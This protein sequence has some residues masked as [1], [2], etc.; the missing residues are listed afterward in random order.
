MAG[1]AVTTARQ[2]GF[3]IGIAVLGTVFAT[4]AEDHLGAQGAPE[5]EQTAHALAAG[6]A[7]RIL[8]ALPDGLR[9][10]VDRALHGAAVAG[11]D[12]GFLVSAGVGLLGGV[13]VLILVR[14]AVPARSDDRPAEHAAVHK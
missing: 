11:L 7:G 3:A 4:R 8:A 12:A 14:P 1:G 10:T 2:L 13:A 5:P 6:Q 9:D